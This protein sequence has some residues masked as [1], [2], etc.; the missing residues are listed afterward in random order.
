MSGAPVSR[1][2]LVKRMPGTADEADVRTILVSLA[3]GETKEIELTDAMG[4]TDGCNPTRYKLAIDGSGARTARIVPTCTFS[5]ATTAAT[6]GPQGQFS[7]TR[8]CGEPWK[9]R[10]DVKPLPP[11]PYRPLPPYPPFY[12][13][14]Q[15]G[16]D[17]RQLPGERRIASV[18]SQATS[19]DPLSLTIDEPFTGSI[20]T[21]ALTYTGTKAPPQT[22][23]YETST[24]TAWK[25]SVT[26]T[27]RLDDGSLE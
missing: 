11:N 13:P 7:G 5:F 16:L 2:L 1:R 25:V 12:T 4:L 6:D 14:D 3:K 17:L 24:S 9:I 8:A 22:G 27:C 26:P 15:V 18:R 20:G 10:A 21:F 23:S 19:P